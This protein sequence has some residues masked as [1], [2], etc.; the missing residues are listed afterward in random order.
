MIKYCYNYYKKYSIGQTLIM[1][2]SEN[3]MDII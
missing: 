1:K 3:D 2:I